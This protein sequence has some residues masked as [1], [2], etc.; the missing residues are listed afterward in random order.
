MLTK[1]GKPFEIFVL[2]FLI[3]FAF[4]C[5]NIVSPGG[6][7]K[8][9]T[10]PMAKKLEPLNYTT[11]FTE[12]KIR[13]T[14]N[15]Y[16][17][18]TDQ[19]NQIVVSPPTA[20]EFTFNI[21]GKSLIIDL[22][23]GLK[24]ST[25]YTIYFGESIRDITEGNI[26]SG[27]QY[28]FST[29]D[30]IDS[31]SVRGSVTDA[32]TLEPSKGVLVMLYQTDNDSAPLLRKPDYLTKTDAA[33]NFVL[34]NV[35]KAQY[36]MFALTDLDL[37]MM[38][39]LPNES[40]AFSDSLLTPQY[41]NNKPDTSHRKKD[42]LNIKTDTLQEKADTLG[43]KTDSLNIPEVIRHTELRM[44]V[45]AD[46]AQKL[47]KSRSDNYGQF[48]LYFKQPVADIKIELLNKQLPD[49]WKLDELYKNKDTLTCWLTNP[50]IDTLKFTVYDKGVIIDT[51]E[52]AMK[53]K[54]QAKTKGKPSGKG[55]VESETAFKLI[56]TPNVSPNG[57]LPYFLPLQFNASHP[58]EKTD[59]S[60]ISLTQK[61]D[62][63]YVPLKV[64]ITDADSVV[65]RHFRL[66][67]KWEAKK[68]Y[69]L[70]ILP[71]AFTD[72]FGLQNDSLKLNFYSNA[73]ED[74]G[75]FLFTF[76]TESYPYPYIL[77]L[78]TESR[79]LIAERTV[80]KDEQ[81]IFENLAPGN[82]RIRII[83]DANHDGKWTTGNYLRKRQPEPLFFFPNTI[84]IRANW[85]TD[86]EYIH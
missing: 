25:T 21:R 36:K 32:Y 17:D 77:Q 63:N 67:Y 3:A 70:I 19:I 2:L 75:R 71:G 27:F 38:Y 49:N 42:T 58:V 85:D 48:R 45:Q 43:S 13:I 76:K 44:F 72:I 18:L 5:A 16:V 37:D 14:F 50:E 41:V 80:D 7:P 40:I 60:K 22:P 35:R 24:D 57:M 29:G 15:E 10:P 84:T 47:L 9:V 26:L 54:P 61:V 12:K 39:N 20:E 83:G 1:T 65:K 46:T 30:Y 11:H 28:A 79:N 4:S 74:Y 52:L 51:V 73:V 68:N 59:W 55:T 34:N 66:S 62:S 82:Y 64:T 81:V 86:F 78:L 69:Q 33:G 31:L 53:P 8:D 56:V 23:E 6:G